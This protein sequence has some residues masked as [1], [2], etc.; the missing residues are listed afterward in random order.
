MNRSPEHFS[1]SE[2]W[3]GEVYHEWNFPQEVIEKWRSLATCQSDIGLFVS[4]GWFENWWS[5]FGSGEKLLVL[6]LKKKGE[7]KA[8]FPCMIKSATGDAGKP[9]LFGSLTNDHTCHYDFVIDRSVREEA[10]S[11]FIK[12]LSWIMSDGNITF[13]YL[14]LSGENGVSFLRALHRD[15]TPVHVDHGPWAPWLEVSGD[16]ERFVGALPGRLRNTLKRCRKKA[17]EKGK[18]QFEVIRQSPRLDETLDALFEIECRSWKGKEGT[19]IKSDPEVEIF[20]RRLAHWA[21]RENS[22]YLFLLKLDGLPI[23]GSFC[24][25]SGK[26]VFLLKP[27]YDESFGAFSPGSL[28]QAEIL[29]YL[30]TLPE[31]SVYNFLGACDRWKMEWTSAS[32]KMGSIRVYSKS[33]KGW[34]W[35]FIHEGWKDQLKRFGR[36]RL[37]KGLRDRKKGREDA[38]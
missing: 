31:I 18:L 28:L 4:D 16:W 21:M 23:A 38:D 35:Y 15:W 7:T 14:S 37:V 5:A 33:L 32:S 29:K 30:F 27:G 9:G 24:L 25:S 13:E 17:E 22:L 6:V 2:G 10:L 20:Y 1:L 36:I 11:H 34:G 8:I 3:E 19:A 12:A 26:T